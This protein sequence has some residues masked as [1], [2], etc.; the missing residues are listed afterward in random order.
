MRKLLVT[1][2]DECDAIIDQLD[3]PLNW[4]Y[5]LVISES[6]NDGSHYYHYPE[7]CEILDKQ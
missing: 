4:H 7:T 1:F 6:Y 3:S 2:G 5:S